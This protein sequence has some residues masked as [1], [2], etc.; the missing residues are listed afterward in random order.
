[1]DYRA[2]E[3][4]DTIE[5]RQKKRQGRHKERRQKLIFMEGWTTSTLWPLLNSH[6]QLVFAA[7]LAVFGS[8]TILI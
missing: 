7:A 5:S 3:D 4:T 1:M 8:K 2:H 6:K